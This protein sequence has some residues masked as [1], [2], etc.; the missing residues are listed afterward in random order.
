MGHTGGPRDPSSVPMSHRPEQPQYRPAVVVP[1]V[2]TPVS[3]SSCCSPRSRLP[4]AKEVIRRSWHRQRPRPSRT[5]TT[6]APPSPPS[7]RGPPTSSLG[8]RTTRTTSP[9]TPYTPATASTKASRASGWS[10]RRYNGLGPAATRSPPSKLASSSPP[11]SRR[12]ADGSLAGRRDGPFVR[13][14]S[15]RTNPPVRE[16]STVHAVRVLRPHRSSRWRRRRHRTKK[17]YATA[18]GR[19][20]RGQQEARR[21]ASLGAWDRPLAGTVLLSA[22]SGR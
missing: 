21:P 7:S 17:H 20:H 22:W 15:I 2:T 9:T 5:A 3:P 16:T 1:G 10:T 12:S 8:I 13:I 14:T 18:R 6:W 11:P 19:G 4:D